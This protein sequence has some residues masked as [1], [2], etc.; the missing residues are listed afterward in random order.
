MPQNVLQH[1]DTSNT[2]LLIS[3]QDINKFYHFSHYIDSFLNFLASV[4]FD[5]DKY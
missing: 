3:K 5:N 4:Y 1:T 2:E